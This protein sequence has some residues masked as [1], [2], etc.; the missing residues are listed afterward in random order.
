MPLNKKATPD[1]TIY[2]YDINQIYLIFHTVKFFQ[3][4]TNIY[5]YI[6]THT[7]TLSLSLCVRGVIKKSTDWSI[8]LF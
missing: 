1:Q 8:N 6:Y 3:K 4:Y 5:I 7:H 2:T